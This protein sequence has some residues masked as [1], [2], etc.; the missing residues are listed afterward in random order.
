MIHEP[1]RID[2]MN[3]NESVTQ[4]CNLVTKRSA[5]S[6]IFKTRRNIKG[7]N[8]LLCCSLENRTPFNHGA[9][10]PLHILH[11]NASWIRNDEALGPMCRRVP[12][13]LWW[14]YQRYKHQK[15]CVPYEL[16]NL[17]GKLRS[18]FND[19]LRPLDLAPGGS[20]WNS[21]PLH[22]SKQSSLVLYPG[23]LVSN[24]R[25]NCFSLN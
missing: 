25:W 23:L 9:L 4:S 18:T 20:A 19:A 6:C 14:L 1:L 21:K 24:H 16:R 12:H 10:H 3:V 5:A 17:Y 2:W 13:C 22:G 11:C 7:S 15:F 8:L